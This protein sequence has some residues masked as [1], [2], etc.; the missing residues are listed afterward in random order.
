[1]HYL[2]SKAT[3]AFCRKV[4]RLRP[5][6]TKSTSLCLFEVDIVVKKLLKPLLINN[7]RVLEM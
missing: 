4:L 3:T 7:E 2:P 5:L 1:M 6:G